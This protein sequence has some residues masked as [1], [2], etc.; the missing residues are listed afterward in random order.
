MSEIVRFE[1]PRVETVV[2]GAGASGAIGAEL[3]RR[4]LNRVFLVT[5]NTVG[6]S[7]PFAKL[8]EELGVRVVGTFSRVEAHNPVGLVVELLEAARS[9]EIDAFVAV[10]GGSPCDAAKLAAVGLCEG[11]ITA[12]DLA[13]NYLDF[14]Y[15]ATVRQRP[16]TGTP[17]PVFAVPTTL[18]AAEW[19]GFAGSV[20]SARDTKDL[21]VY[22]EATPTAVFLD[23]ELCAHTPRDL[24]ATTGVRALDHAV[25]TSYAKNAHPFTTAL[26]NDALTILAQNLPR[27]VADPE[28][29]DAALKCQQ[30]A[31]M[32][33][34]GVHNV[35]LGLSH[36]IG[37]QLG[38]VG[39]PH[40][41]TSCIMLPHVMRFLEPVTAE[42]QARM[43]RALAAVQGD[44]ED[45]SAAAR[46][47]RILDD[48]GVPRRVSDFGVGRD[49]MQGVA[50]AALGDMVVRES[51]RTVDEAAIYS[52][53]EAV[54]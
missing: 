5:G 11:S 25:E 37:H 22:L 1:M 13:R 3:D 6:S 24:W 32:S 54:W 44:E 23:P 19:D 2:Q 39:I 48:L 12:Q 47:E 21:T 26:A 45:L 28:D 7:E 17:V 41:V 18:S 49:K 16:L 29:Y 14:E 10:G 27:S 31:W 8:T 20:D 34:L 35:S 40:G 50:H 30:A 4:G 33:I 46:L 53:L 36:A 38:A 52:L 15:P 9:A 51:P 42:H 43:A